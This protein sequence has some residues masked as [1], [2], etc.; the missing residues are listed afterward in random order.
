[1]GD[2]YFLLQGTVKIPDGNIEI[3]NGTA[4]IVELDIIIP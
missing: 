1:M 4:V 3:L 2:S